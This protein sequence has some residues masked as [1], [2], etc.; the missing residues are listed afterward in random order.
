MLVCIGPIIQAGA[1]DK[2]GIRHSQFLGTLVHQRHKCLFRACNML[3]HGA[4]AVVGRGDGNGFEHIR[5]SH[6]FPGLQIDLAA[7]L[8]CS[9]FRGGDGI[10]HGN[11]AAVHR[12]HNQQHGHHFGDTG[13]SQ[14]LVGVG[15]VENAAGGHV[16][17]QG[18][19]SRHRQFHSSGLSRQTKQARQQRRGPS[20]PL[21]DHPS[22]QFLV[23]PIPMVYLYAQTAGLF[24]FFV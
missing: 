14:A 21:H 13:R 18:A 4:G 15:F 19:F 1:V 24:F 11:F 5:H 23:Q 7:S 17:Q 6:G 3:C 20:N 10:R 9:G 12:F 16:H 2:G 22:K 8:S